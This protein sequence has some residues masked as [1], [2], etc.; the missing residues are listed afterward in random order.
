MMRRLFAAMALAIFAAIP[1]VAAEPPGNQPGDSDQGYWM[2][3]PMMGG[4][5]GRGMMWGQGGQ[6]W[7]MGPGMMYGGTMMGGCMSGQWVDGQ[8][9][10]LKAELKP[11]D[12]QSGQWDEFAKAIH[13]NAD[14]MASVHKEMWSTHMWSNLSAL[15]RM[16][17]MQDMMTQHLAASQDILAALKPLY[18]S[19]SADQKKT[20]DSLVPACMGMM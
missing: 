2:G 12:A 9:A 19:L 10:F 7:R 1:V 3:G 18:G 14:R 17:K 11:T 6:G 8:L 16:E 5:S 15:E 4:Q 13:G 20:F